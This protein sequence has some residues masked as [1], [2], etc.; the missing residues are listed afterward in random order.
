MSLL[1]GHRQSGFDS[2]LLVSDA[3]KNIFQGFNVVSATVVTRKRGPGEGKSKG[4]GFVEVRQL[5]QC[6]AP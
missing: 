2:C 6:A 5:F 4:F 1:L 3:L